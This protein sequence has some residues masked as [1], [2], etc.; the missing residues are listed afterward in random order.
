MTMDM[1]TRW[2]LPML[3]AGQAQKELFHNEAL[4]LIDMLLHGVAQSADVAVPPGAPD[5]GQCWIVA[6]GASGA[7]AGQA[8]AVAMW[9]IGGWRFVAPQPGLA[10]FV[11]DRGHAMVHDGGGW[12]DAALQADALYLDGVK[13]VGEQSAAI[14]AP[15]GGATVDAQARAA[16]TDILTALRDHGLIAI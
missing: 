12:Q 4:T 15:S 1:T 2:G 7:W 16:I 11:I 9:T 14:A 8:G 5:A 6:A 13:V 10:L 3:H